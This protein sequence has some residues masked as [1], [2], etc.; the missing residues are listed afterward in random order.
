MQRSMKVYTKGERKKSRTVPHN[1][2]RKQRNRLKSKDPI[3]KSATE[4]LLLPVEAEQV[5]K[6][7]DERGARSKIRNQHQ[8]SSQAE[9]LHTKN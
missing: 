7:T 9:S 5:F 3:P 8:Q 4:P 6:P 1:G 2:R